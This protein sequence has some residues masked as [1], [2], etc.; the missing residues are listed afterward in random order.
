MKSFF[1][2]LTNRLL[3]LFRYLWT[4]TDDTHPVTLEQL[5]DHLETCGL[6]RP[7]S[8]TLKNDIAQLM[9]FGVDIVVDR[10]VQNQY[11]VASRHFDT[12]EVKL[13]I[14]A[15]QSSR[16]IT[17]KK[18]KALI[19]KLAAFVE[20]GQ[21]QL[22]KRQLYIDQRAK[23][24][25]EAVLRI[26]DHL[27][28]A[29]AGKRKVTFQYFDY[30]PEKEKV[31][32]HNGQRYTVSPYAMLWNNDLYYMVGY[33][34]TKA[35]MATYRVDRIDKLEVTEMPAVKQPPD[36]T[37]ADYFTQAFSMYNG[38]ECQVELLCENELMG[39]IIDRFGPEVQTEV[40]DRAHFKVTAAV[41]LSSNFY[42]WVF[43]SGS[44][45]QILSPDRAVSDFNGILS[46]FTD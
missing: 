30:T 33:S 27:Y 15:V 36:F 7:D 21:K 41:A 29:I 40:V 8:R 24:N 38:E 18:S 28:T 42:G 46:R 20:P 31:H 19:A 45:M 43:A 34:D 26:V 16:F 4:A 9:E 39:S 10:R 44:K 32:R 25:N 5:K 2:P 37:I 12:A 6:S 23:A 3:L 35:L 17:P 1:M 11:F 14:D 13:L 22:L